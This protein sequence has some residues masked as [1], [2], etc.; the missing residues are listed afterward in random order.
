MNYD[1]IINSAS[2]FDVYTDVTVN[3]ATPTT[4]P[5]T[6]DIIVKIIF[7]LGDPSSLNCGV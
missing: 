1:S 2:N 5:I 3:D 4:T 6:G 7:Y